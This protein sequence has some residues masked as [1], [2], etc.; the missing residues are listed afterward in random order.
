MFVTS[1]CAQPGAA[2]QSPRRTPITASG[3]V[4]SGPVPFQD[5]TKAAGLSGWK[6]TMGNADKRLI[7]DTN[8]SGVGLI[9]YD[10]DGWLDIYMVNGSTFNAMDGKEAPPHA[11][12]FHNNH[13]GTFTDVAVKAGVTNDRWGFGVAV[14]DYDNDGWPDMLVTNWGKNRLYHNNH[15]DTFT[16]V[17]EKAGVALGN[18]SDGATW[19]DYDGD[20]R[21]DL[22]ISGYVHFDRDNLPYEHTKATGFS[23]CEFRG[24]PVMCGPKNLEG[25]PDHLLLNNGDGTFKDVSAKAGVADSAN[26]YYGITPVFVDVNNDGKPDLVV[27]NDSTLSYLYLNRGDGT[28]ED[29]SYGTGFG[30][31]EDGREVAAMGVAVG[32]YMND[33]LL[34]FAI[35][36]FSDESKLLFRNQGKGGFS[37]VS[38]R[39]G[40]GKVSIPFLGWGDGF[41]DY[42]ND[43]WLDLM[44]INGHIYPAADR[45]DWGTSYAQRSLLFQNEHNGSF[46]EV[47]PVKGTALA[48]LITGRGA[49]FGDLFNDGKIDVVISQMDGPPVLLRDINPDHHHWVELKL[50]GGAKSPR[51]AVGATTYL[52]ANGTRQR[53]DVISGGS[54]ISTND[55]R[56][57]FG[58]GDATDPGSAEIHWPS[59]AKETVKLPA[60]DRIYTITEGKG[61]TYSLCAGKPCAGSA[62]TGSKQ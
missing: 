7:I 23:Y 40:I 56:L 15:D 36:D 2:P 5:I 25:E 31:N 4:D 53:Q 54:Y 6:H 34:D 60:V 12:L 20:G 46:T 22:F 62:S 3:F 38:M 14:A 50:I 42:D 44:F 45:L 29:A 8:G 58:L 48:E 28:F 11:A 30:L 13:D 35:S 9:D 37:E 51:D 18:W 55:P 59:G 33:G 61:I 41:L 32:D 24:E 39:S 47:P 19:G 1:S 43:G 57:H 49:A 52:T 27:A 17:A 21:L 16:D 26:K 10:N